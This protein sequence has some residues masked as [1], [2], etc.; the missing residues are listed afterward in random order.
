M[1][2][3]HSLREKQNFTIGTCVY[4]APEV[5]SSGVYSISEKVMFLALA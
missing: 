2:V 5:V 4:G 1:H 3:W